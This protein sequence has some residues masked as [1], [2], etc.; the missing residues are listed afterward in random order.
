MPLTKN[1]K[2][3]AFMKLL[4]IFIDLLLSHFE[5]TL[6]YGANFITIF[7]YFWIQFM[8]VV[9]IFAINETSQKIQMISHYSPVYEQISL[10]TNGVVEN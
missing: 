2:N 8:P 7:K 1:S 10:K 3:L 5:I 9:C 4:A 6:I